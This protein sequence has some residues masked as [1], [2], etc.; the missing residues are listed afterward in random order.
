MDSI[1]NQICS[2]DWTELEGSGNCLE[3]TLTSDQLVQMRPD[4]L[5]VNVT[6]P[7]MF[8]A[9]PQQQHLRAT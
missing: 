7:A 2:R 8:L 4:G 9:F 3:S 5:A 1:A 6:Q